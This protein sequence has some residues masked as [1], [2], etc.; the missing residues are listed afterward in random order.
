MLVERGL[1]NP[2]VLARLW[3]SRR[4]ETHAGRRIL[5]QSIGFQEDVQAAIRTQ[6]GSRANSAAA[7]TIRVDVHLL[8][9]LMNL[10]GTRPDANQ[11]TQFAGRQSDPFSPTQHNN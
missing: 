6:E 9:R 3:W 8:D 5:V 7:D 11:I 2:D 10:W 4:K 1:V